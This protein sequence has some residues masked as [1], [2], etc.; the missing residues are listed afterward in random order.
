MLS[1]SVS[2]Q[3]ELE[4]SAATIV[5]GAL[6]EESSEPLHFE[7]GAAA[8]DHETSAATRAAY[9]GLDQPATQV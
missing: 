7:H 8:F 9:R 4:C 3:M 6:R 2:P 5:K 1:V